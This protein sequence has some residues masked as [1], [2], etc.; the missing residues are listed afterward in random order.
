MPPIQT[1]ETPLTQPT[2]Q[3]IRLHL[4]W[5]LK[6]LGVLFCGRMTFGSVGKNFEQNQDLEEFKTLSKKREPSM[7]S[8]QPKDINYN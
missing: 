4:N 1:L 7:H 3:K 8:N 6:I 5:M 2:R